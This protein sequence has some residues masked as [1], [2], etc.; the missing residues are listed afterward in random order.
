M[1]ALR[2]EFLTGRYVA[3]KFNDR[4]AAEWPPDLARVFSALVAT[5]ADADNPDQ[6][7]RTAL[8]WIESQPP[9]VLI[10]SSHSERNVLTH[11]VPINDVGVESRSKTK[12]GV[13]PEQRPKQPRTFPTAVPE[14]PSVT[15]A[16]RDEPDPSIREAMD[17]LCARVVRLGH[18]SSLVSCRV[19]SD[20]PPPTH[21]PDPAGSFTLRS[22]GPGQLAALEQ[23][24]TRHQGSEP[25]T[26][27]Y[28]PVH[29]AQAS[30]E[31]VASPA[32]PN[33]AGD[34][35][36]FEFM[37]GSRRLPITQAVTV[38][39]ALRGSL[40]RFA[41]DPQDEVLSGHRGDGRPTDKPHAAFVALPFVGREHADGRLM[42]CAIVLP[43]DVDGGSRRNVLASLG[44]WEEHSGRLTLG[45]AGA[46]SCRRV[47]GRSTLATLGREPWSRRSR[48]WATV[49]PIALPKHPG[50]L[51][52]SSAPRRARAWDR[53]EEQVRDACKHS[54][55][56]DPE[57][58]VVTTGP[59]VVGSQPAGVFPAFRQPASGGPGTAR[60]LV[61]AA[62]HF[63][64][65][66]E[67]PVLL[68][69]GRYFG[70]G[71]FRPV[72]GNA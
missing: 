68:G 15:F 42:G 16:W 37:P 60:A 31:E 25:R 50:D 69:A 11:F 10:A 19:L 58:V 14:V 44:E 52:A 48:T 8:E 29:Y 30:D 26:L 13:L 38:A 40:V 61:H 20:S 3:T 27:P 21:V 57:S 65:E 47:V 71:L 33:V 66:V 35:F 56:P 51:F 24:F 59:L 1:L 17:R 32:R 5:W 12:E 43:R 39:R 64:Q 34:W 22:V 6:S 4:N 63:P 62:I 72:G 7:E 55:L 28:V 54:G 70:L 18:S 36:V 67:G 9:P 45:R 2:I 41:P 23:A 49:T 53:A 46:V